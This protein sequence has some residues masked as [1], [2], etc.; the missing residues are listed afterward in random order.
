MAASFTVTREMLSE[1]TSYV[2]NHVNE[3]LNGQ[4]YKP[5][6]KLDGV[7]SVRSL[8]MMLAEKLNMLAPLRSW[9]P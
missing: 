6:L 1:F 4:E 9:K 2:N 3:Q 8:N 5:Q 7:L